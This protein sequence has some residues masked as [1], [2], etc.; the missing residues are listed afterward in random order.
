[1]LLG[2]WKSGCVL[3]GS[4]N[5]SNNKD[6]AT[7]PY[8]LIQMWLPETE[9]SPAQLHMLCSATGSKEVESPWSQWS[10]YSNAANISYFACFNQ[11]IQ[12][13]KT[14]TLTTEHY[15]EWIGL[16]VVITIHWCKQRLPKV[17][18]YESGRQLLLGKS[19]WWKR[20]EEGKAFYLAKDMKEGK[21]F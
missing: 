7:G 17:S 11:R 3:S 9:F 5:S 19:A 8:S 2:N 10:W 16:F 12:D 14:C 20:V 6:S 4:H 18:S 1:M 15:S 13:S 21:R